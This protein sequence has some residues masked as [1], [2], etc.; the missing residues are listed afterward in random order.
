[1]LGQRPRIRLQI[2][3]LYG[4]HSNTIYYKIRV[5]YSLQKYFTK[6]SFYISYNDSLNVVD[7]AILT[8]PGIG[9]VLPIA[10]ATGSD[11]E[12]DIID[13]NFWG[14]MESL[15]AVVKS[16]YP[17]LPVSTRIFYKKIKNVTVGGDNSA[18]Y[19]SGGVDSTALL[20]RHAAEK[21]FL[22]SVWG[23]DIP[24]RNVAKWRMLREYVKYVCQNVKCKGTM[25]IAL[26][27][28]INTPMLD[29]DFYMQ[30]EGNDWWGG[31]QAGITLP[32]L[33]APIAYSKKIKNVYIASGL[34]KS[35]PHLE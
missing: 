30:L 9:V 8:I 13:S 11:I 29:E 31:I 19:F 10:L 24:L 14:S 21:P 28:P 12:V 23:S 2:E 4:R 26:D 1:M 7:P 20:L 5:P 15:K 32:L 34:P 3:R 17:R 27:N 18:I 33:V 35:F 22:V 16:M 25:S 6:E